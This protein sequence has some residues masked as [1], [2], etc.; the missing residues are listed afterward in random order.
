MRVTAS[1]P[2]LA[3]VCWKA[4]DGDAVVVVV[5]DTWER[6]D[7]GVQW[8]TMFMLSIAIETCCWKLFVYDWG[9]LEPF[10]LKGKILW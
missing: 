1:R 9:G 2:V 4:R 3:C 10:R 5:D 7:S 6:V 8:K